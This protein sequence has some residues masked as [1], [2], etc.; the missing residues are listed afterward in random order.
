MRIS[1]VVPA[2]N[3][4]KLL[5]DSLRSIRTGFSMIARRG[6]ATELIVCDN[7]STDRTAAIAQ[8]AGARVVFEPVNQI[9]RARNTGAR[10]AHGNWLVFI[11]AD[12]HPSPA[13]FADLADTIAAGDCLAGGSTVRMEGFHPLITLGSCLWNLV[14]RLKR[15]APG[16]FLFC[17]AAAF[18]EVGGFN[19]DLYASE[20]IDLCQRLK[21]LARHRR[22][23]I[24][25]LHRHPLRTSGRKLQSYSTW[26]HLMFLG[27][28]VVSRGR[29][30]RSP[31]ACFLWYGGRR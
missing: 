28:T 26:E 25:I 10:N 23:R 21:V 22:K 2:F 17:E 3:E 7:N 13:L 29:T 9:G 14:S 18:G 12:S 15:W 5:A 6:W 11:D 19:Q 27:R 31:E 8:S 1:V 20:E 16:S 4:E 30:L 24:V